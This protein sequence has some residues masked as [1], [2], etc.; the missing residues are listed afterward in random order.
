MRF[1][2]TPALS[3]GER[4]NRSPFLVCPVTTV[5]S[6]LVICLNEKPNA[7]DVTK[8]LRIIHDGQLQFPLP[9]GAGKVEGERDL[10]G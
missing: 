10:H 7:G 4:E 8:S 3:L 2:L 9:G 6:P 5:V 1:P